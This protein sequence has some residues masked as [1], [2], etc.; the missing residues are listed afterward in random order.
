[1][2]RSENYAL[3]TK[4][5]VRIAEDQNFL[6][7]GSRGPTLLGNFILREKKTH[8]DH[9]RI[10]ERIVHARGSAAHGYF[11]PNKNLSDITKAPFLCDPHKITPV[12]VRFSTVQG[13]AATADTVRDIRGLSTKFY[14]EEGIFDLIGNNTPIFFIQDAHKFPD[15]L[16]AVKPEPHWAK[17]GRASC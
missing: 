14:T 10:P 12:F 16:H 5:G 13:D 3:T 11:Q 8:F 1:R 9:E 2:K 4:Q 6:C 7:A 17:I 15:F